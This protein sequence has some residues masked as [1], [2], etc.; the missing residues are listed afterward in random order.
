[1]AEHENFL[2]LLGLQLNGRNYVS[3]SFILYAPFGQRA[4]WYVFES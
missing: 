1:M 4:V 3:R 2:T